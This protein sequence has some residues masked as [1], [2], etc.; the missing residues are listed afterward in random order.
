MLPDLKEVKP[1]RVAA[2]LT[3]SELAKKSAV[4]QSLIAKIEAGNIEPSYSKT[5][6]LF[7]CLEQLHSEKEP[8]AKELMTRPVVHVEARDSLKKAVKALEKQGL[9]QLPVLDECKPIGSVSE[10]SILAFMSSGKEI[11]AEKAKAEDAMEEA[12]PS[13]QENTPESVV[14]QLLSF[15][16]AVL[17]AKKGKITGIITKSNLLERMI[18]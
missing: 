7:D 4:S 5:K 9:S 17:V 12:L 18:K 1:R 15:S 16:P 8:V 13:I 2:G 3:Q 10:K 6:R 11:D 14:R